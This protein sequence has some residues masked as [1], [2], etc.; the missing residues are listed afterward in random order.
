MPGY[1]I[2]KSLLAALLIIVAANYC[3]ISECCLSAF[4]LPNNDSKDHS[5]CPNSESKSS[6]S[7]EH[8]STCSSLIALPE[9]SVSLNLTSRYAFDPSKLLSIVLVAID[10][11]LKDSRPLANFLRDKVPED[12]AGLFIR[13]SVYPTAPPTIS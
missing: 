12:P 1:K 11:S 6:E 13:N 5:C 10:S 4:A 2:T 3:I 8:C 9:Q 7:H